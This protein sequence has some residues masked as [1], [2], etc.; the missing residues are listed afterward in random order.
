M[1]A[2]EALNNDSVLLKKVLELAFEAY[3]SAKSSLNRNFAIYS[4]F[5]L[6]N[7]AIGLGGWSI[8]EKNGK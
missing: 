3:P 5:S 8:V 4:L 7:V 6:I 1:G 2:A